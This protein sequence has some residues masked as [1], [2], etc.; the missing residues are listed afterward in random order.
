MSACSRQAVSEAEPPFF[1]LLGAVCAGD[2]GPPHRPGAVVWCACQAEH[3]HDLGCSPAR[4]PARSC[5]RRTISTLGWFSRRRHH[6]KYAKPPLVQQRS[7]PLDISKTP[8]LPSTTLKLRVKH[9]LLDPYPGQVL[10]PRPSPSMSWAGTTPN[11]LRRLRSP[12]PPRH[13]RKAVLMWVN[14]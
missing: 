1:F 14:S 8:G 9:T 11:P 2:V 4:Q 10:P 12:R 3:S 6:S 7:T 13:P 5:S